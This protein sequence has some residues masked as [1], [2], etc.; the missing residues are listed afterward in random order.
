MR[1]VIHVA[2]LLHIITLANIALRE[3]HFEDLN[4]GEDNPATKAE[5][6]LLKTALTD[7]QDGKHVSYNLVITDE[8]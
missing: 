2:A 1:H 3:H 4:A 6:D 5:M 7:F 8:F